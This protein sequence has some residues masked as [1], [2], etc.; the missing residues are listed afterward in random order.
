MP[1]KCAWGHTTYNP[2]CDA[3]D[4]ATTDQSDWGGKDDS[5]ILHKAAVK[6]MTKKEYLERDEEE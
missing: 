6:G 4:G 2:M 1:Y 3:C 5:D